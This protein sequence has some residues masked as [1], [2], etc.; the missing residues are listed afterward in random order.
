MVFRMKSYTPLPPF[1][2]VYV[3]SCVHNH[4]ELS[5]F[6]PVQTGVLQVDVLAPYLIDI[7]LD[8]ILKRSSKRYG[9]V[10]Q[11]RTSTRHPLEKLNDLDYADDIAQLENAIPMA[12]KQL[13]DL[14][15][16]AKLCGLEINTL[17]TQFTTYTIIDTTPYKWMVM[18]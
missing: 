8:Y 4:G 5:D 17:K 1:T 13:D 14:S 7:V 10:T 9:F 11:Q 15:K 3:R 18:Y 16:E 12:Q 2:T 6:F